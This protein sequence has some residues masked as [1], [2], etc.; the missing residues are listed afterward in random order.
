M[1][2]TGDARFSDVVRRLLLQ[3][4]AVLRKRALAALGKIKQ[5]ANACAG[6]PLHVAARLA[7][8]SRVNDT[9]R[10]MVAV[11]SEHTKEPPK[12]AP[13]HFI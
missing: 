7:H 11:A 12:I 13:L 9:R 3:A 10:V 2:E 8:R 6:L 4:E 1:G 5:A